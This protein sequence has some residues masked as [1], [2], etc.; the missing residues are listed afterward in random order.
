MRLAPVLLRL[1]AALTGAAVL[2]AAPAERTVD[3]DLPAQPASQALLAFSKL[4]KIEVLFSFDALRVVQST[5]V[6]GRFDPAEALTRLLRGTGFAARPN[7]RNRFVVGPAAAP[8]GAIRGRLLAPDGMAISGARLAL[9]TTRHA[10]IS[11]AEGEFEFRSVAPGAY[12]LVAS[13]EGFRSLELPG[14]VVAADATQRL[15]PQRLQP[16]TDPS[17]LAPFLVRDRAT[18][19][20]P[21]DRSETRTGPRGPGDHLDLARTE[22]DAIPFTIYNRDQIARS[23]V[24]N[25]NEFLQREVLDSDAATRPPEQEDR[26]SVV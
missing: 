24:V 12:R 23:G 19:E 1:L 8:T 14:V 6:T 7:G 3:F 15:E 13:A 10:T 22:N 2:P 16:S 11:D 5:P 9:P 4:T 20:N 17:S 21:F 26:K 25:L 18:R